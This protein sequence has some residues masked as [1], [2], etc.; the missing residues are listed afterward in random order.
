MPT[1]T[2]TQQQNARRNHGD[3]FVQVPRKT[4]IDSV[5]TD[6][7]LWLLVC[8]DLFEFLNLLKCAT[9][10]L[11]VDRQLKPPTSALDQLVH[12]H[13]SKKTTHGKPLARVIKMHMLIR[14]ENQI[15]IEIFQPKR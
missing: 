13:K 14:P 12:R 6:L 15:L 11:K 9:I 3:D 5:V 8:F 1:T 4:V 10:L 7:L 2:T